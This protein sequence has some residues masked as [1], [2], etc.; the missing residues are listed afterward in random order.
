MLDEPTDLEKDGM[1]KK[2][3]YTNPLQSW[4]GTRFKSLKNY[5]ILFFEVDEVTDVMKN[6]MDRILERKEETN[7]I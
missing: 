3:G 4:F 1:A 6:N 7:S 2:F 5:W